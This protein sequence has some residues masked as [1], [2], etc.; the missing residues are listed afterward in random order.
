MPTILVVEDDPLCRHLICEVLWHEGYQVAEAGDGVEALDV[1]C[2]HGVNLVITDLVMPKLNGFK[3][4]EQLHLINPQLPVIFIT[5]YLSVVTGKTLL[6]DV[7]EIISKP[8]EFDTLRS[9]VQRA[10]SPS[11]V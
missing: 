10:L 7:A 5:G 3:F 4:L 2:T 9:A 6:Q 1:V 11:A 8:F